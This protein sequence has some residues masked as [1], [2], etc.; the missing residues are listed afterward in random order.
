MPRQILLLIVPCRYARSGTR[1]SPVSDTSA[2]QKA[3]TRRKGR[4]RMGSF[5]MRP[6]ALMEEMMMQALI[7]SI[8]GTADDRLPP[9]ANCLLILHSLRNIPVV[10]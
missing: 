4:E 9:P 2:G 3:T 5:I 6:E 1:A 7:N 10:W 8:A